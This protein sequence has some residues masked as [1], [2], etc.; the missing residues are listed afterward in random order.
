VKNQTKAY[1]LALTAVL[2]WSTVAT[3]FKLALENYDFL[4]FLFISSGISLLFLFLVL[5]IQKKLKLIFKIEKKDWSKLIVGGV[6][7][8]FLYYIILFNAYNLL[9]AQ[10]AQSLNYTWPIVLVIFSLF[11]FKQ[12]LKIK[13]SIS[14][15][16]GFLGVVIISFKGNLSLPENSNILGL[17]LATGSSVVWASFW[18]INS[19]I[20]TDTV[21]S[22]FINFVVAFSL[23]V[24]LMF[25]FSSFP[26]YNT[27]SLSAAIYSGLFE[28]GITFLVWMTALKLSTSTAKISNL[29]FFAPFISLF[30]INMVLKEKILPSTII[31][32]LVII[33][34]IL[35]DK[36]SFRKTNFR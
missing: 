8:P 5:L 20:K 12:K 3:A 7:N 22:L 28:M 33:L 18:I 34:G 31:G 6:L 1:L 24:P 9:P 10:M 13:T 21:V 30:I 17:I 14:F 26:C 23:I 11:A 25:I 27:V 32:L 36:I 2:F 35:I 4:Q 16:L 19:S 15:I 29:I